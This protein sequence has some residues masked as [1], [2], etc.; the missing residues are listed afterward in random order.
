MEKK[1]NFVEEEKKASIGQKRRGKNHE[2]GKK[3]WSQMNERK[4]NQ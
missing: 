1:K 3:R 4:A 2:E